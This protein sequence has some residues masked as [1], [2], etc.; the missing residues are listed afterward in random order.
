MD[1]SIAHKFIESTTMESTTK[2]IGRRISIPE[3]I[4]ALYSHFYFAENG[5]NNT[6]TRTLLPSFQVMLIFNFGTPVSV[7]LKETE[8]FTIDRF[9]M[10]GPVKEALEYQLPPQSEIVVINFWGDATFNLLGVSSVDQR[11]NSSFDK[12]CVTEMWQCLS[13][14][15]DVASRVKYLLSVGESYFSQTTSS[16]YAYDYIQQPNAKYLAEKHSKNVRTI[17]TQ[18]RKKLGFSAKEYSRYKRFIRVMEFV[19]SS[20]KVDKRVDWAQLVFDF[21]YFDQ[22]HLIRDFKHYLNLTPSQFLTI[23]YKVCGISD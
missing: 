6:V 23:Q 7:K 2:Y 18:F 3:D 11:F 4:K 14:L 13:G 21:G 1:D 5:S 16:I 22:S 17:Q 15:P 8:I 20:I 19:Q 12:E 9:L 10:L